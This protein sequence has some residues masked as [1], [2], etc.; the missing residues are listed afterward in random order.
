MNYLLDTNIISYFLRGKEPLIKERLSST[1]PENIFIPSIVL[2]ELEYGA[3]KSGRYEKL[4]PIIS[5]FARHFSVLPF[6]LDC[7]QA[8]G[9][10]RAELERKGTPI[11]LNELLIA[12]IALTHGHT[13]VTHNVSEF[14][15]VRGLVVL[16]WCQNPA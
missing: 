15:R 13:L 5:E 12:S 3:I 10:I 7:V 9:L 4:K 8:Y 6:D 1:N 2:A 14:G 16:D 11:G